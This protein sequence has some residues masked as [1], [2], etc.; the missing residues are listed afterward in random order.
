MIYEHT[1]NIIEDCINGKGIFEEHLHLHLKPSKIILC[2][3]SWGGGTIDKLLKDNWNKTN[4]VPIGATAYI[5]AIKLGSFNL[6]CPID[7]R[8]L[9]SQ[10]HI[11]FYQNNSM[12]LNGSELNGNNNHDISENVQ[13]TQT[14]HLNIDDKTS[15]LDKIYRFI[16]K[17]TK[18]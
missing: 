2:G 6:G 8:P 15:I 12:F 4:N 10:N 5:D 13:D 9:Y 17:H 18:K 7:R 14:D 16:K 11:N 1:K 3:Y